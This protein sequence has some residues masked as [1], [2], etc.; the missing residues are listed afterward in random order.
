LPGPA[1]YNHRMSL[2][3]VIIGAGVTGLSIAAQLAGAGR[4][5]CIIER[6]IKPGMETST[7]NSGVIHAGLYY[8]TGSLK[9]QLCVDG[10]ARLYSF[11]AAHRIPHS[12]CGKLVVAST[13][14]EVPQIEKLAELG[15][16]NGA[17]GLEIVGPQFIS[18]QEPHVTGIAALWSPATGRVEPEALV[19]ALL[20]VAESK[21]AIFLRG[22]TVLGGEWKNGVFE[23]RTDQETI[24]APVVINAAGL[25][26]DET[27]AMLGGEQFTIYPCRGEYAELKKSRQA[28]LNGL[29]Y[30]LPHAKGHGLGVHL[31]KTTGGGVLLGPTVRFQE[32]KEDYESDRLPVEEFLEPARQLMPEL[33]LD[34]LTYGGSGIRP[35]L[36]GPE[37][38]FA[39]FMIRPDRNNRALI[40]AAGI[41]SPGL[42]ACLSIGARVTALATQ[43]LD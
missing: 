2:D 21:D 14:D 24:E 25:Y 12:R 22:T 38:S 6:H 34:D 26:A 29:V 42:T 39:D 18:A 43:V 31:T 15:L 17:E 3:V 11:C 16:A 30:P 40:H 35:K 20:G 7:H 1:I 37:G 5:V 13:D 41:D 33:S 10:A 4:S 32:G 36:H 8:P 27:S 9:A 23:L 28:W 19:K